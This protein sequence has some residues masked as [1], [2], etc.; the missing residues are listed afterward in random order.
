MKFVTKFISSF[1]F[2]QGKSPGVYQGILG[3][4][5]VCVGGSRSLDE[6]HYAGWS[7]PLDSAA[8]PVSSINPGLYHKP[9]LDLN[10]IIIDHDTF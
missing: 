4:G 2:Q 10:L 3:C 7:G 1:N 9:I 8:Q 6:T 5:G